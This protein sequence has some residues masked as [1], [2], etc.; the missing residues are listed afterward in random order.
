MSPKHASFKINE[1]GSAL[2]KKSLHF[3]QDSRFIISGVENQSKIDEEISLDELS[4]K[5]GNL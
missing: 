5:L 4:S 2:P 3:S 1:V